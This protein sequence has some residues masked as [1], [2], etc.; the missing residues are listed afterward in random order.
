MLGACGKEYP[1]IEYFEKDSIDRGAKHVVQSY[2]RVLRDLGRVKSP[3]FVKGWEY[4]GYLELHPW[5]LDH[6]NVKEIAI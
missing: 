4:F 2:V 6:G 3:Y 5:F 1:S